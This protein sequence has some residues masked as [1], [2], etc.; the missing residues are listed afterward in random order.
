M[1][2]KYVGENIGKTIV[3]VEIDTF[4]VAILTSTAGDGLIL[5][6]VGCML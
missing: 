6:S 2:S 4:W 5:Y 1:N 3:K